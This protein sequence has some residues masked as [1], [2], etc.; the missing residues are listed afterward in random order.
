MRKKNRTLNQELK[1]EKFRVTIFGSARIKRNHT[2]Y[3]DIYK[4]AQMIGE[5]NIDLVTGGGPGLMKA[6][7]SGHKSGSKITKA[8]TI[9]LGIKLPHEQRINKNIDI[10]KK[11]TR[12]SERLDNFMLLSNAVVVAHGGIGT[13]LELMFTWQLMQ[14]KHICNIPIIL[15]GKQ[16]D[17]LITWLKKEPLRREFFKNQDMDLLFH[18]KNSKDAIKIIDQSYKAFKKGDKNF[19][20]N[21]KKYKIT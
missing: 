5:K 7:T 12:F 18:A 4:L 14:V 13:M 9:G 20:L 15:L 3:K 8:Q 11:F 2:E 19:C 21:Y 17:G 16:W 6:A 10:K 1:E